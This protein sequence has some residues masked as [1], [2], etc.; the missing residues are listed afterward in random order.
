MFKNKHMRL[1]KEGNICHLILTR[2]ERLNA[3]D[4]GFFTSMRQAF[5]LI[6]ADE[7]TWVVIISA[8]GRAFSAGTDLKELGGLLTGVGARDR[9]RLRALVKEL[10]SGFNA[11]EE[12]TRPVIV[13]IHGYC[14]GGGVDLISACD[15]RIATK[16][17]IFSIRETR[18][19]IV[20]DLGTMQRLPHII[21]WGRFKELALT[22]RDFGAKEALEM[23]LITHMC[24]DVNSLKEKAKELALEILKCPPL[25]VRAVKEAIT[26]T[27]DHGAKAG[28]DLVAHMNAYNLPSE[29]L[30]EAV[31]AF[32]EKREPK[33]KGQ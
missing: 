18:M 33:F 15:I 27:R 6:E 22:G 31:A 8:E 24:E 19:A 28:L 11:V 14:L 9:H 17:A 12:C 7:D 16:D 1:E 2:P 30:F 20:P 13:A 25:I 32:Q 3:M 10:Q 23:G 4:R 21:G 29:D 26:F 5:E